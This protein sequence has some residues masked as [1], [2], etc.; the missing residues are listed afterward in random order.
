MKSETRAWLKR[1]AE[2]LQ[3]AEALFQLDLFAQEIYYCQQTA[4]TLLKAFWVEQS[5]AGVPPR[6]HD[7]VYLAKNLSVAVLP[8]RLEFL[9]KLAAQYIPTRYPETEDIFDQDDGQFY[10]TGIQE[11]V[12]W[13]R[14]QIN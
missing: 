13:L 2:D 4:E 7:L 5:P 11:F 9:Q 12:A 10:L 6:T 3:A 1:A 8:E 14:P